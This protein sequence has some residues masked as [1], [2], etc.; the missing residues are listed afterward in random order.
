MKS[1]NPTR[2]VLFDFDGVLADTA[3]I[4]LAAWQRTFG[5]MGWDVPEE[6]CVR[7]VHEDDR[8][9]LASLLADAGMPSG[10][11]EG[12]VRRKQGLTRDLLADYPR[13]CPG[14]AALVREL[15]G[16]ALLGIVS[17]S[18]KENI[19]SV[20]AAA[21]L[22][23]DFPMIVAK[24]DVSVPKPDP[25]AYRLGLSRL[26]VPAGSA[27]AIEDS[28]TGCRS[29][30]EAGLRCLLISTETVPSGIEHARVARVES[31]RDTGRVLGILGL[32]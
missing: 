28:V 31:L 32:A 4:H 20:L 27:W 8:K 17:G 12:W 3:N 11:V 2:A 5:L 10:D 21:D 7:A 13:L 25:E 30:L 1:A 16:R 29:A 9:F 18:W 14:A 26:G 24:E 19:D 22:A 15:R 6:A 23:G